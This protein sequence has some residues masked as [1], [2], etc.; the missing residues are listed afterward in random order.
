LYD[1]H[2][3]HEMILFCMFYP[4]KQASK[5]AG[6]ASRYV[7]GH[8]RAAASRFDGFSGVNEAHRA[9]RIRYCLL[10]VEKANVKQF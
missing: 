2:N 4:S 10:L 3:V 6:Q 1:L 7:D 5:Q 8:G 9:F